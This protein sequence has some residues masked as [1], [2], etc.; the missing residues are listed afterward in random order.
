MF[1]E[2]LEKSSKRGGFQGPPNPSYIECEKDHGLALA[3]ALT[4]LSAP[5]SECEEEPSFLRALWVLIGECTRP[6]PF[7]QEKS[8]TKFVLGPQSG[9]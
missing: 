6:C 4:P 1:G 8:L 7:D 9:C 2:V 5:L 3:R